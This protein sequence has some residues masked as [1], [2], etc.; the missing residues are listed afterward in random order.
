MKNTIENIERVGAQ[1]LDS[2]VRK[3]LQSFY[4]NPKDRRI[5]VA[6]FDGSGRKKRCS[7][8]SENWSPEAGEIRIRF[9]P[10]A[11]G[12]SEVMKMD[13]ET[14]ANSSAPT[15]A[16]RSS[17]E[18]DEA[19]LLKSRRPQY[20]KEITD[21]EGLAQVLT[22]LNRAEATPG[23]NFVPLRKFRDEILSVE[24]PSAAERHA[25]LDASIR[26]R[27][28]LVGRVPNPKSPQFPVTTVRLNRLLPEVKALLGQ[29]NDD[30]DDFHPVEIRGEPLSE[31]I[32]RERRER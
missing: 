16:I 12:D 2:P 1:E 17:P 32:I 19:D 28:V 24:I 13:R 25:F 27:F 11:S 14:V 23:W 3:F 6:L 9:E 29:T 10:A 8:S 7:A 15:F 18:E 30:N 21:N 22:S 4:P 31:T 20:Q 26:K 5:A